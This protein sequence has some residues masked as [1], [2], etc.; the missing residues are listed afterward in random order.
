MH[1]GRLWVLDSGYG[2]LSLVDPATG[3]LQVVAL[4]PGYTRGLAFFGPFAFVGQSRIRETN[5]FG[6][7][8]IGQH[9]DKLQCG[10]SVI[11]VRNGQRLAHL[12]FETG[13]EEIFDV[14]V[15]PGIRMPA[16]LGPDPER[17]DQQHVWLA[18]QPRWWEG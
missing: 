6:G 8:P 7:L 12:T 14:Q 3:A 1:D 5:V 16:L 13:V 9:A 18:G 4:L 2:R 10:V 17:D 11:D 15:L